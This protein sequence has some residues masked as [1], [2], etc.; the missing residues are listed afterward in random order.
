MHFLVKVYINLKSTVNDPQ[1]IAVE[2][3]LQTLGFSGI[4]QIRTGKY[5]TLHIASGNL[6]DA[7]H[8]VDEACQKLLSN[9]VIETY[10]YE[11][12]ET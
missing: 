8:T 4:S 6:A 2:N 10:E 3:A 12:K 9:P 7:K 1:G 11:I 5:F